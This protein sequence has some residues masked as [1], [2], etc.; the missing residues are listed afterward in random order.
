[1]EG[2]PQ[3]IERGCPWISSTLVDLPITLRVESHLKQAVPGVVAL[4]ASGTDQ[5]AVTTGALVIVV[6][7]YGKGRSAAARD[8]EHAQGRLGFRSG[9]RFGAGFHWKL[10]AECGSGCASEGSLEQEEVNAMFTPSPEAA[11]E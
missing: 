7:G 5:I 8:Q 2:N 3:L 1:M 4:T 6:F 11:E 10:A 9:R